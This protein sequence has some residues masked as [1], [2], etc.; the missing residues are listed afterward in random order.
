MSKPAFVYVTYI[1]TT[2]EKLWQALIDEDFIA[3]YWGGTRLKSDWTLG[4]TI[5]F[6]TAE[7]KLTD[8]GVILEIDPPRRLSFSWHVM[9][10]FAKGEPDSRVTWELVPVGATV[11]LTL[12]NDRFEPGSKVLEAVSSG[13]PMIISCMK[14]LLETGSPL[15][16]SACDQA[17]ADQV[18]KVERLRGAKAK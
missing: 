14:T 12:T 18:A 2:P 15:A 6:I 7:G 8:T 11:K 4:S 1:A 5:E 10:E 13:W 17:H 16:E 3:Q 9:H